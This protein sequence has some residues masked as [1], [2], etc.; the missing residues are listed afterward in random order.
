MSKFFDSLQ[1]SYQEI[2]ARSSLLPP[3]PQHSSSSSSASSTPS[4]SS[5]LSGSE[6]PVGN[7]SGYT[8]EDVRETQAPT[9]PLPTITSFSPNPTPNPTPHPTPN[10]T[11][12]TAAAAAATTTTTNR[13]NNSF[14][15]P[16]RTT[17]FFRKNSSSSS[18]SST[19]ALA[20]LSSSI[21]STSHPH[22]DGFVSKAAGLVVGKFRTHSAHLNGFASPKR[23]ITLENLPAS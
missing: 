13:R 2:K 10:P 8:R 1:E 14:K 6:I 23:K 3:Q 21:S 12:T 11:P 20:P 15:L 16:P 5:A 22:S 19:A 17:S 4:G 7:L 9:S 18:V